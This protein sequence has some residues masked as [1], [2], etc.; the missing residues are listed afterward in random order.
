M[1]SSGPGEL[2]EIDH[3]DEEPIEMNHRAWALHLHPEIS[4]DS[5]GSPLEALQG[6]SPSL[7]YGIQVEKASNLPRTWKGTL[8]LLPDSSP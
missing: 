2:I 1:F 8:P 5:L 4:F 3:P 6:S 7:G